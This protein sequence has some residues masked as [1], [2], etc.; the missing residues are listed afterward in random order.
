[1]RIADLSIHN[2]NLSRYNI[3]APT[4]PT[5]LFQISQTKPQNLSKWLGKNSR[6]TKLKRKPL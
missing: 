3:H 4:P 5:F 1:M 6:K 2:K